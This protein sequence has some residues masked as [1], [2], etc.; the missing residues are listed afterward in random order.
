MASAGHSSG[1]NPHLPGARYQFLSKALGATMWFF[2]F[3]RAR[4][5]ETVGVAASMGRTRTRTPRWAFRAPSL[6]LGYRTCCAPPRPSFV[7]P[8][9]HPLAESAILISCFWQWPWCY[10]R[11]FPVYALSGRG[12]VVGRQFTLIFICKTR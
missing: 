8:M 9:Y 10:E 3:Y 11:G 1:F 5:S 2:I 6:M 7:L 12:T 4:W